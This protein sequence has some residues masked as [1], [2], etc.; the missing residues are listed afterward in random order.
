[1]ARESLCGIADRHCLDIYCYRSC[2]GRKN[3]T[4]P[5]SFFILL[6]FR[7]SFEGTFRLGGLLPTTP[8]HSYRATTAAP[9]N[10]DW[11]IPSPAS[12]SC[13]CMCG[14][15]PKCSYL[16]SFS[17]LVYANCS[18]SGSPPATSVRDLD[19]TIE[20]FRRSRSR[21]P[22]HKHEFVRNETASQKTHDDVRRVTAVVF[23]GQ[24]LI[25]ENPAQRCADTLNT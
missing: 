9:P 3:T 23:D 10:F 5:P 7:A 6:G 21:S 17:T 16:A 4:S 22:H 20:Y 25:E 11:M 19:C 13:V 12:R 18:L 24:L 2:Q 14:S 15:R 8:Q 1:M